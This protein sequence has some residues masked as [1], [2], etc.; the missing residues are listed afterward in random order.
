MKANAI[1]IDLLDSNPA[2]NEFAYGQ[3]KVRRWGDVDNSDA[4]N[5]LD[6]KK[7]K[8]DHSGW[9][10]EP[11]ADLDGNCQVNILDLKLWKL[12]IIVPP[13]LP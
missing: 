2:N 5:I 1:T 4:I 13:P 7:V 9:I 10:N 12:L 6:L 8:L 11:F 3:V